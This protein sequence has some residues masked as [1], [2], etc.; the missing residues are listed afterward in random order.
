ML[1]LCDKISIL[2]VL[3][4]T[5]VNGSSWKTVNVPQNV[6]ACAFHEFTGNGFYF[7]YLSTYVC[8]HLLFSFFLVVTPSGTRFIG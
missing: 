6:S 8:S 3:L 4:C 2:C 1:S 5:V 7:V